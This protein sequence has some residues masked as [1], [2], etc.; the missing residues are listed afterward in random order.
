MT[1]DCRTSDDRVVSNH[2]RDAN[3]SYMLSRFVSNFS[4]GFPHLHFLITKIFNNCIP[5]VLAC[6]IRFEANMRPS[7]DLE[8]NVSQYQSVLD[9]ETSTIEKGV[10]TALY[11]LRS[12]LSFINFGLDNCLLVTSSVSRLLS[13]L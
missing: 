9:N 1:F 4:L 8:N 12:N 5:I 7:E 6:L 13:V 3:R 11:M 10:G 2:Q